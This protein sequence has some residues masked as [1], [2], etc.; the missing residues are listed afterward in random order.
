V[1]AKI[2]LLYH[3]FYLTKRAYLAFSIVV[4]CFALSFFLSAMFVIAQF[5][6]L[7]VCCSIIVDIVLLYAKRKALLAG[8]ICKERFSNGDK[9]LVQLQFYNN[10]AFSV[11]L[12]I[13]DELPFQFQERNWQRM[14][15]MDKFE[16]KILQ[17]ELRPVQRGE[18]LFGKIQALV[19]SPLQMV[20][21][22]FSFPAEQTVFVYPSYVQLK[23]YSLQ[24]IGNRLSE[25]GN[26]KMRKLGSSVEFEQIKD[27][28]RGDDYR[29]IN[30]KAT[31]RKN[32]LMANTY[33]D[34]KSQQVF[35]LIDKSRNMRS[36]F[37]GMHL[38]DYAINASLV[39]TNVALNKQ[40]KVGLI[41]F[42]NQLNTFLP[43]NRNNI[44]MQAVLDALY[45][46]Q[47][48]FLDPDYEGLYAH[49]RNKI[50]QRSLL[51]LFTNFESQYALERQLPYL[52]KI[53]HHHL[54][55]V[56]IFENTELK[57]MVQSTAENTEEI[58]M[59]VIAEKFSYEKRLIV[60]ELQKTG[61][62]TLLTT[63]E[64][65]TIDA[66]NKYIEVKTR[67]AI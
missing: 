43:A 58:Y 50:K 2:S 32:Q 47:T 25:S 64:H 34:E 40:D 61:I 16:K 57:K 31:A 37:N 12:K 10:Y 53:A 62:L 65:L 33:V 4:C 9:N 13:I 63:P 49:I 23:K 8:R 29:T 28:V 55:M 3:S 7:F 59:Q 48:H 66:V 15:S 22:R 60:K 39:V 20:E 11:A 54:L 17:Y 26:K 14:L 30:W 52:K 41:S 1:K 44:Q 27:Y 42:A 5:L 51:I 38:L 6:L 45:K 21:R 67:Q 46:E 35:C 56:I 18:Y 19:T 36:P 24:A